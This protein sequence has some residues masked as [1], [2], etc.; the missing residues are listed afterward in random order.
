ML[1]ADTAMRAPKRSSVRATSSEHVPALMVARSHERVFGL[2][3]EGKMGWN[4]NAESV[5]QE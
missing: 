4:G 1:E 5:S 2:C 3:I